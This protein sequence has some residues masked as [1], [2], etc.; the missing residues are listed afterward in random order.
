MNLNEIRNP[1]FLR[2]LDEKQLDELAGEIREFL[3]Q[4]ISKTGGHLASN[5]GVVELTIALHR[6]FS[7]P[8]DK[9]FF[10][11]GHQCYTHKILTG[12]ADRFPTL[13]Q[14]QGLSG[15][16]KR[17]ESLYDVWEAGHSSTSLS[18][19]LGMAVARDLH[20][21]TYSIV[22]VIGD[23]ALSSGMS[24]EALNQIGS[25]K[26]K[27]IIVFNDNNMSISRN[28]GAMAKGF[29]KL[30]AGKGYND[31]KRNMKKGLIRNS[32][33]R[34][35]Y[36][37]L[38]SIK[39]TVRD[40]II[41]EGIFGEFNLDYLGPVDGHNLH[42]LIEALETARTHER[43]VVVH[44]ITKK[45][46][47]YPFCEND[48]D[49]KWHGIGPF[50]I[51][52]GREKHETPAG[53]ISWSALMS[54]TVTELAAENK[55]IAAVTPAMVYGSCLQTFFARY[56]ERSFDCGISEEHAATFCAGLALS[57]M[58]PYFT[59]YSSFLQRAYDQINH[60][61]CRMDLPVVIGIDRAGL[62]G[63]DGD[64]H[65]G[66]F[67]IG[68]L[69]ALPNMILAAPS[70][71]EE[72]KDMLYTAFRTNHPYAIRFSK[73]FVKDPGK[74]QMRTIETGKWEMYNDAPENKVIVL[75]YGT[76]VQTLLNKV[77]VNALPVTV[78]NCRFLKPIDT[79]MLSDIAK[80]GASVIVYETDMLENG[81]G[82]SVLEYLND[83]GLSMKIRRF[84]IPDRYV[85]QGSNHQLK[86]MM[87]IDLNSLMDEIIK[88]L[89]HA[90]ISVH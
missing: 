24:L 54:N 83:Q 26:R 35:V 85:P 25:E 16:Q 19:A 63:G 60:D 89:E 75:T 15:F 36:T 90:E 67:D 12:R 37:G 62:C 56:P 79:A 17:N 28:V 23:G 14:F 18:A 78:V 3:I 39:D 72:A 58:R 48:I 77:T 76:D 87:G 51:H 64:T 4:N 61:I 73:D 66:V 70:T 46:K 22:P 32:V 27:I 84:G 45:G 81:L 74:Y 59:V 6:V 8:E 86:R 80:R 1:D 13:K 10:D 21:G 82:A 68:L 38:K 7:V 47:G 11:V 5:L 33:G 34:A 42:D 69:K 53:F 52:T 57:G 20:H 9:V 43:P 49:G 44:V 71:G 55:E 40:T 41:D 29:S 30:R 2:T 88:D 31:L 50:D 65:H